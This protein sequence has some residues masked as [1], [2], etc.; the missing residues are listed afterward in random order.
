MA[1]DYTCAFKLP[2]ELEEIRRG[3]GLK[4]L[5]LNVR[6]LIKHIEEVRK[7]L[8]DG[9][10]DIVILSESWLHSNVSDSLLHVDGYKCLRLDRQAEGACGRTKRGG[11]ICVYL[12]DT[13]PHE[14]LP[15]L[16]T[17]NSDLEL[18]T[19][20]IMQENQK[21]LNILSLYRPPAGNFQN[22]LIQIKEV[23]DQVK[24]DCNGEYLVIGDLNVDMN[25]PN[26]QS[27][28]LNQSMNNKSLKQLIS[29]PSRVTNTSS[30]LID[31]AYTDMSNIMNSGTINSN[32]SDHLPIF[33]IKKK[34]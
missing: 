18:L 22:A 9:T 15:T 27:R 31:L 10:G 32:I 3:K 14:I 17:S 4:I 25:K 12:K 13:L 34:E 11:G 7:D 30:S 19:L 28:K 16:C 20:S 21:R 1:E 2:T 24:A 33:L 6:S 29:E 8:L 23:I 5:H 26:H